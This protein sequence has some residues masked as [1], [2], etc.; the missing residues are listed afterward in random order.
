M[1]QNAAQVE[2]ATTPL[3]EISTR[4]M[5]ERSLGRLE[6][7]SDPPG[8]V[9]DA[10][11]GFAKGS[12][13]PMVAAI[14]EAYQDHRPLVLSPDLFWLLIAQGLSL[15]VNRNIEEFRDRFGL[16]S[17]KQELIVERDDLIKGSPENPWNEVVEEFCR[18]IE[19]HIGFENC[20]R[21]VCTFSTTGSAERAAN[22]I[23]LMDSMK[24]F[25][26]YVV[27]TRCGIP[28]VVLEGEPADW[29]KLCDQTESM[30]RHFGVTWWTDRLSPILNRIAANAAGT[31]DADLWQTIYK[32][33]NGSGGDHITGWILNFFPYVGEG[34]RQRKTPLMEDEEE[35]EFDGPDD[36]EGEF[37]SLDLSALRAVSS[38]RVTSLRSNDL[39]SGLS[40]AP[41]LW[42]YLDRQFAME[43][44]AGFIGITQDIETLRLRPK[45]G[46]AIRPAGESGASQ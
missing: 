19:G 17:E 43:F 11:R 9:V 31:D 13:H 15:H 42:K 35:D 26:R 22:A 44:I 30:G 23:V 14:H 18:K 27:H 20:S 24:S 6:C 25:F 32:W 28:Q 10:G 1:I 34:Q 37:P 38:N 12:L 39:P 2:W 40:R 46:W 16:P 3:N 7:L 8:R 45:I 5:L 36:E 33:T 21:F 29:Q 4:E 41:F